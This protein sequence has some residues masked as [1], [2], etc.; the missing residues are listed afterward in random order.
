M[1]ASYHCRAA[2]ESIEQ[3][4]AV[5]LKHLLSQLGEVFI[6]PMRCK[7]DKQSPRPKIKSAP[8]V[9]AIGTSVPEKA[10]K[11]RAISNKSM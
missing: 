4:R 11:G 8:D 7:V 1:F 9:S 6:Q 3:A 2:D 5:E 10:L